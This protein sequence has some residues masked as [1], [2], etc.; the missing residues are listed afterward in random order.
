MIQK[1]SLIGGKMSDIL[2]TP[3][4]LKQGQMNILSQKTHQDLINAAYKA[5]DQLKISPWVLLRAAGWSKFTEDRGAKYKGTHIDD[6]KELTDEQKA[7][8]KAALGF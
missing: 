6:I 3:E 5:A 4:V 8:L 2:E 1:S 7:A